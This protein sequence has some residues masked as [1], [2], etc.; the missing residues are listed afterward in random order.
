MSEDDLPD[1]STCSYPRFR[2]V[3]FGSHTEQF[4][5]YTDFLQTFFRALVR[6]VT[7]DD[8]DLSRPCHF[9][10][11][12]L[13]GNVYKMITFCSA[14]PTHL[15]C[16]ELYAWVCA[17][18]RFDGLTGAQYKVY[19]EAIKKINDVFLFLRHVYVDKHDLPSLKSVALDAWLARHHKRHASMRA[20]L[21]ALHFRAARKAH[22]PG[23][24]AHLRAVKAWNEGSAYPEI[25]VGEKRAREE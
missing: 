8:P 21:L 7:G 14:T 10:F 18:I 6:E 13:Y 3:G 16:Q 17:W 9:S 4:Q 24:K 19:R 5:G 22:A 11:E 1:W 2:L 15:A 25:A 23:G 20:A 12:Q